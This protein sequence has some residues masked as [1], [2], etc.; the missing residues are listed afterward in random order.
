MVV[1][2]NP[3]DWSVA[4]RPFAPGSAVRLVIGSRHWFFSL[5]GF[6]AALGFNWRVH[7]K[8]AEVV[9]PPLGYVT[10]LLGSLFVY[11]ITMFNSHCY[12]K[13]HQAWDALGLSIARVND[14]GV[15][16]Y[17]RLCPTAAC[18]FMRLV[19]AAQ[20][21]L[22]LSFAGKPITNADSLVVRRQLLT[23]E[24]LKWFRGEGN[25]LSA[26]TQ[27]LG[28]ALML[29]KKEDSAGRIDNK[30]SAMR[31]ETLLIEWRQHATYTIYMAGEPVPFPYF[32]CVM[33]EA[34]AF[35]AFLAL[36]LPF[37]VL[38]DELRDVSHTA[39]DWAGESALHNWWVSVDTELSS[40]PDFIASVRARAS[41]RRNFPS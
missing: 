28:W 35:Q 1:A 8:T 2:Y 13:F 20:H 30:S 25:S 11:Q 22:F 4:V 7:P 3:N 29:I 31:I 40:T 34:A 15:F 32:H 21:C 23:P 5:L 14:L 36:Y 19:H 18:E 12:S 9:L 16:V 41:Q 17:A 37:L 26:F 24:E 27:I 6:G 10:S 39:E 38:S 33:L